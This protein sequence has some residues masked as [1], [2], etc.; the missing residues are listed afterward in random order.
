VSLQHALAD[1]GLKAMN[2]THRA[3]LGA[4]G[5]RVL[6]S[7]FGMPTTVELHTTGRV[8]GR[9]RPTVLTAPIVDG[10]RVG[11][12]A[13]KGGD[14]RDPHW[15]RNLTAR[16]EVVLTMDGHDRPV[17]ARTATAEERDELWPRVVAAYSGYAGDQRR[18]A[19]EDPLVICEP[20]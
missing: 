2:K 7:A 14:E 6:H 17:R 8:S 16:P 12:V 5:G 1:P 4:T 19:R 3:I 9:A 18:T 10:D 13:S 11:L 15:Y 20:R